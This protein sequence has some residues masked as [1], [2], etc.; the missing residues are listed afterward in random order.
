MLSAT[1]NQ[2]TACQKCPL[3]ATMPCGAT[4]VPGYGNPNA[5]IVLVGEALGNDEVLMGEPFVG[6]AG[7]YL[8]KMLKEAGIERH[9]LYITNAVHCRPTKND[10]GK[11]NRPPKTSEIKTCLPWAIQE[12][13]DIK[14]V[15]I[16][17]LG[18]VPTKAL[19]GKSMQYPLE[20]YVGKEIHDLG[21][22][23]IPNYHPSYLM[24]RRRDLTSIAIEAFKK[25][26]T[27]A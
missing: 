19:L 6:L 25:A 24:G 20:Q 4:P 13:D 23:I 10:A 12:I 2:I 17:P 16:M 27:W 3:R 5:K 18:L 7:K 9:N 22:I 1:R 8:N 21:Y 14:P 15:V 11:V 26:N